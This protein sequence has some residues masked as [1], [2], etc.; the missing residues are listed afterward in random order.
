MLFNSYIFLFAF[1]P[2]VLI[3]FYL[4]ARRSRLGAILWLTFAS[5]VFYGWWSWHFVALLLVSVGV[6]YLTGRA[7]LLERQSP[8]LQ[9]WLLVGGIGF[10]VAAIVYFK[11]LFPFLSFLNSAGA[12]HHEFG[13]VVLPLGISFF[14]FTQIGF[15]IECRQGFVE[16]EGLPEYAFFVTFFPHLISGP[17]LQHRE[18]VAQVRDSRTFHFS[19]E[20]IAAGVTLFIIGLSKKCLLADSFAP[21]ADHAFANPGALGTVAAW[22][23]VLSYS[24]QLYFDFSGYSDMALGLA[25]MFNID[26]PLNFYS[27]YKAVSIIDYWQR[28]NMSLTRFI[29]RYIYNPS[30][31]WISRRRSARGWSISRNG[32]RTVAG[33]LSMIVVPT[34]LTWTIAGV[35]HGAGFQFVVFGLLHATYVTVNNGWRLYCSHSWKP[36]ARHI[37]PWLHRGSLVLATYFAVIVGE[38]FFRASSA[39]T[40]LQMLSAIAG[41]HGMMLGIDPSD[42]INALLHAVNSRIL[43][44]IRQSDTLALV[45]TVIALFLPLVP[46]YLIVWGL[47]NSIE[48]VRQ[49][50]PRSVP[51]GRASI[52]QT[53][54]R[55]NLAWALALGILL[56]ASV[57]NFSNV[58][59]FIYFQF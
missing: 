50:S 22:Q 32:Q 51:E 15:L 42:P 58:Q 48:I 47:P 2:V 59:E 56:A 41:T 19:F 38:I 10:N 1:L 29:T 46:Y 53:R 25:K 49:F 31:L 57:A 24:F 23:A 39:G 12:I 16:H 18:I 35:W 20:N 54:W 13:T 40:A 28:W 37:P 3:G 33:F 14:T 36:V 7:I 5:L 6:N 17:I 26:F 11:Y 43:Y 52:F 21:I 44:L 8:R 30:A 9:N 34:F 55:P 45:V 27:P 4:I